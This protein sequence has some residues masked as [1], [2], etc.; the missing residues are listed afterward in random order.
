MAPQGPNAGGL[1]GIMGRSQYDTNAN[2]EQVY[3]G[4]NI[5]VVTGNYLFDSMKTPEYTQAYDPNTMSMQDYM[6]SIDDQFSAGYKKYKEEALSDGPSKWLNMSRVGNELKEQTQREGLQRSSNASTAQQLDQLAARGGLSSGARER[7]AESGGRNYLA[8]SQDLQRQ[9]NQ[10]DLQL[11]ITDEG[12][13]MQKLQNLPGMEQS[14]MSMWS[15][16]RQQDITNQMNE[17]QRLNQYNMD[18]YDKKM[19]A[20]AAERQAQATGNSGKK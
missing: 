7:A 4:T 6:K 18:L 1:L 13:R 14:R 12:N 2:G 19:S 11:Q 15:G 9:G 5:P 10:N 8:M 17:Q 16:A 20:A 3:R